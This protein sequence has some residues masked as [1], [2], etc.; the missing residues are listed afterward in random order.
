MINIQLSNKEAELFKKF[1]QHQDDIEV[2]IEY[3]VFDFKGGQAII[4][5]DKDGQVRRIEIKKITYYLGT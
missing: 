3:G 1:R 2:L 4:H 5:R